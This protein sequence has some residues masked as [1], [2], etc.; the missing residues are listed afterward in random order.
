MRVSLSVFLEREEAER[1]FFIHSF[2][3]HQKA[4]AFRFS[5]VIICDRGLV[6]VLRKVINV[7]ISHAKNQR[8]AVGSPLPVV[9]IPAPRRGKRGS[10]GAVERASSE[11]IGNGE[12]W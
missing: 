8:K 3:C 4:W 9:L 5:G 11:A 2:D 1:K 10:W 12:E 6:I 7:R